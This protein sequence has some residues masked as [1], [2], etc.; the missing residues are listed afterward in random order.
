[1]ELPEDFVLEYSQ[2]L[3]LSNR[4][5][6]TILEFIRHPDKDLDNIIEF[7]KY[8]KRKKDKGKSSWIIEKDLKTL[9]NM[10]LSSFPVIEVETKKKNVNKK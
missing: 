4:D 7:W 6:F 2:T 10:Y 9:L 3:K 8:D 5:G 1:M